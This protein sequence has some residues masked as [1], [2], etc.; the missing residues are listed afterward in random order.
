[1]DKLRGLAGSYINFDECKN[2]QA[3]SVFGDG[4]LP[5]SPGQRRL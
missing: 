2:N 1:M 3:E 4:D 5:C